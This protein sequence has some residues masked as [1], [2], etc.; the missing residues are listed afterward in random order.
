M[1]MKQKKPVVVGL[2]EI[3]WDLLPD[4]RRLGGAPANFAY[5]CH[6]LGADS[7]VASAVGDDEDG[8]AIFNSLTTLGIE[9]AYLEKVQGY[10]T[11]TVSV[12]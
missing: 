9:T 5:H 12:D 1:M 3:L 4:G 6:A 11:G 10:P 8:A 7:F 2:G